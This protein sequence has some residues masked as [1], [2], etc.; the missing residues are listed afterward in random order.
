MRMKKRI[1]LWDNIKFILILL[2][3]VG[4]FIDPFTAESSVCRSIFLFM[5]AFHMPLFLFISGLFHK[6]KEIAEKCIFYISLGFVCKILLFLVVK[7]FGDNVSFALLSDGGIPWF[8]FV[9]AG[10]S[11]L[12]Y[13]LRNQNKFYI[14]LAFFV[15]ALFVGYDK[16]V[17]DYLYLSRFIVFYPFYLLGN[18]LSPEK[19]VSFKE[20]NKRLVIPALIIL[21]LWG[22][23]CLLKLDVVYEYRGLFTGRN[24]YWKGMEIEGAI[25]RLLVYLLSIVTCAALIFAVPNVK[26]PFITKA[27]E[28]TLEIYMWHWPIFL[29]CEQF[30]HITN[31]FGMGDIGKLLFILLAGVLT[32][33]IA[34]IPIFS[35]PMQQIRKAV[36][37]NKE[38]VY[39]EK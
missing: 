16:T 6:D 33:F 19:I 34:A 18:M 22:V 21:A 23:V 31:L 8:I 11:A 17:G 27:G 28:K 7:V 24:P 30:L 29:V 9:L 10:C 36:F 38:I 39:K 13:A 25:A 14:L 2:V 20:K 4:H 35:F 1:Y 32:V 12:T 26:L 5:Y 3:V 37:K 15:L